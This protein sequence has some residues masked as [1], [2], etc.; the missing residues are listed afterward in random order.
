M[1]ANI[2]VILQEIHFRLNGGK[3]DELLEEKE[4]KTISIVLIIT[5]KLI[6]LCPCLREI[7]V[8]CGWG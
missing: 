6:W 5:Q 8:G 4:G 3:Y 2:A 1:G 7:D